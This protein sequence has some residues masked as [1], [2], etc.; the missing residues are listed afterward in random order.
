MSE[1]KQYTAQE[2]RE[3]ASTCET[4]E[5][6]DQFYAVEMDRAAAMLRQ[7]ADAEEELDALCKATKVEVHLDGAEVNAALARKVDEMRECLKEAVGFFDRLSEGIE[8][9][10]GFL[11]M[12][13]KW[14]KALE[15]GES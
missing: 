10:K 8:V 12:C 5:V 9:D 2:M 7:A 13:N 1:E 6:A 11:T 15:G 4:V 3:V 14:R